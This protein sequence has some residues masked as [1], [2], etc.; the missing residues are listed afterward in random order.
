MEKEEQRRE[1]FNDNFEKKDEKKKD[2][3]E[4]EQS[5][6]HERRLVGRLPNGLEKWIFQNSIAR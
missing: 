1:S 3:I 6:E 2:I 5:H 4:K